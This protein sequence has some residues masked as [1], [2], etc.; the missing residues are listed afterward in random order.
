[1]HRLAVHQV[2]DTLGGEGIDVLKQTAEFAIN[3]PGD[4]MGNRTGQT[5]DTL[6]GVD[7]EKDRDDSGASGRDRL[8]HPIAVGSG[9]RLVL[10]VDV[11][12]PRQPLLPERLLMLHDAGELSQPQTCDPHVHP[13]PAYPPDIRQRGRRCPFS[14]AG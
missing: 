3:D 11:D 13:L 5:G 2:P 14:S 4:L 1:M 7:L 12:R 9:P 10:R 8:R 6:I